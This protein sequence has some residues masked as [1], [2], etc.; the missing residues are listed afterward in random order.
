MRSREE[1]LDEMTQ[2]LALDPEDL[3]EVAAMFFDAIEERLGKIASA[4]AAGD[5]EELTRLVHGLKGDAANI[6]FKESSAV[7]RTLESQ[8]RQGSI[9]KIVD[10]D[11]QFQ[12]LGRAIRE[13]RVAIGLDGDGGGDG[14]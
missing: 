3:L 6:G 13:Q 8:C 10:F 4:H 11:R 5:I 7:A 9:D 12:S 1:W 14:P 2:I